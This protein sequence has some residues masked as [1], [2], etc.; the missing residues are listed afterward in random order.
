MHTI[1]IPSVNYSDFLADVIPAW[2]KSAP[3]AELWVLTSFA[4]QKSKDL[5]YELEVNCFPT[6]EWYKEKKRFSGGAAKNHFLDV[7]NHEIGNLITFSDADIYPLGS[8][9]DL[10]TFNE[11]RTCYG[12]YRYG[13]ETPSLLKAAIAHG[14]DSNPLVYPRMFNWNNLPHGYCQSFLWR[15]GLRF[16]EMDTLEWYDIQFMLDHFDAGILRNDLTLLHLGSSRVDP[17]N[18]TGDRQFPKWK[19]LNG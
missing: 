12:F 10:K 6:D 15:E 11:P 2:K 19:G 3:N 9:P 8:F 16:M 17:R 18:W 5:A 4:D 13:C 1:I 7:I 14:I